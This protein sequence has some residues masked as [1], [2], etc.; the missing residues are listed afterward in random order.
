MSS[1]KHEQWPRS[2][3]AL[4]IAS[5]PESLNP[6][7]IAI[8]SRVIARFL[9]TTAILLGIIDIT[10]QTIDATLSP[11]LPGWTQFV[12]LFNLDREFA[13]P[14]W[15]SIML[16]GVAGVLLALIAWAERRAGNRMWRYWA[17]LAVTF[18][19]LSIDEQILAH[20]SLFQTAGEAIDRSGVLLYA[21]VIPG[22]LAVVALGL[23]LIPFLKKLEPATRN[24]MLLAAML[25]TGG[26]L[27]VE[28][29]SG[30]VAGREGVDSLLYATVTSIEEILEIL[31]ISLFLVVLVKEASWRV[32]HVSITFE[33]ARDSSRPS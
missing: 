4:N 17:L 30:V 11:A 10:I 33:R 8:R 32:Q 20:E 22:A 25:Y 26:A 24:R 5:H 28:A 21:W 27:G 12:K 7:N 29:L 14:T 9:Y 15:Y 23:I 13:L 16:L 19:G 1:A 31:G 2:E 3:R 6:G 18:A